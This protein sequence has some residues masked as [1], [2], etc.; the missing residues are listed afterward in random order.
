M[1]SRGRGSQ[2]WQGR[3]PPGF[4]TQEKGPP[5]TSSAR[6]PLGLARVCTV[7]P[8]QPQRGSKPRAYKDF[9]QEGGETGSPARWNKTS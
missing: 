7:L 1:Y 2:G 3:A 6:C 8:C 4:S 9:H 5:S